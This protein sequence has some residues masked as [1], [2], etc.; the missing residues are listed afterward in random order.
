MS[1]I[2]DYVPERKVKVRHTL[3]HHEIISM[4]GKAGNTQDGSGNKAEN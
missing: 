1:Q 3:P 2:I 4:A